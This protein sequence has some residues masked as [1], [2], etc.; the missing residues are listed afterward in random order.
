MEEKRINPEI[1][2]AF[3][4][5]LWFIAVVATINVPLTLFGYRWFSSLLPSSKL[6]IAVSF[7]FG[8]LPAVIVVMAFLSLRKRRSDAIYLLRA[9]VLFMIIGTTPLFWTNI[10]VWIVVVRLCVWISC[11][12]YLLFSNQVR[13]IFPIEERHSSPWLR[14][15][16]FSL[17]ILFALFNYRV[18]NCLVYGE[19]FPEIF[20]EKVELFIDESTLKEN[21][22]SDG[23]IRLA[24]PAGL[25]CGTHYV[26]G[27]EIIT[28]FDDDCSYLIHTD[29]YVEDNRLNTDSLLEALTDE[30]FKK[31]PGEVMS[32]NSWYLPEGNINAHR[33]CMVYSTEPYP[34]M[35]DAVLLEDSRTPKYCVVYGVYEQGTGSHTM[36]IVE[37]IRFR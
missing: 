24:K 15:I 10:S 9:F 34:T 7:F 29:I 35:V 6:F 14:F 3:K 23:L 31:Y 17:S 8:L 1:H 22:Y 26:D 21:E 4:V 11:L 18:V 27:E 28:L 12:M 2:G 30:E 5:L 37:A 13:R 33:K 20:Y 19:P 16:L 25:E 36:D 32:D